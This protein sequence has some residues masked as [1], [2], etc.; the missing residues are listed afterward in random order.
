[1]TAYVTQDDRAAFEAL[2]QR[3]ADRVLGTFRRAGLSEPHARDLLQTTFLHVHRARKDFRL[4]GRFRPWLFAIAM[5]VRREHFRR[6]SRKPEAQLDP[7]LHR[8]PAVGPDTSTAADRLVRRA[9]LQLPDSQREVILLH[10]YEGLSFPEVAEIVGA[11]HA[12]VKVRAHRGY[13]KLRSLLGEG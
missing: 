2:F 11:S 8:E 7:E 13:E 6:L 3:Y 10:W 9:L 1:M 4:D 5:N 12:A